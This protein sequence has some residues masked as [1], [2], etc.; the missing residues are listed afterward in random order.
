MSSHAM[1]HPLATSESVHVTGRRIVATLLDGLLLGLVY[2]V[3]VGIFGEISNPAPWHWE[4]AMPSVLPNVL[5]AVGA[6]AYF[7]LME[8]YVGQ[9]LGKM[10]MGIEVVRE[11][12]GGP[13]GLAAASI[14]TLLRLIDG[15][16]GYLVA[17][18]TVLVSQKRQR[19]G[20]MAAHTLV[21]RK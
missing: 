2:N 17:F 8:A 10:V 11:D 15:S 7:V 9:T 13:P 21:V 12:T 20:D 19:L 4:G 5:Y 1:Y 3:L 14:R 18:I 6:I 16:L